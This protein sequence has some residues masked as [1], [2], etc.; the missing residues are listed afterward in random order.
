M[1]QRRRAIMARSNP[2][3]IGSI[4]LTYPDSKG[5]GKGKL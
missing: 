5:V 4:R 3:T 2:V 1:R